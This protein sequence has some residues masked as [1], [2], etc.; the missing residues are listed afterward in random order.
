MR[1]GGLPEMI[2]AL[3][4][5][6]MQVLRTSDG[7]CY[8]HRGRGCLPVYLDGTRL[9]RSSPGGM[10]LEMIGTVVILLPNEVIA[11][12]AGA[13]HLYTVGFIR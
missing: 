3:Q 13:V 11:Y 7:P 9:S 4:I 5:P 1:G 8:Q 10:P 12:P 6:N 2:R